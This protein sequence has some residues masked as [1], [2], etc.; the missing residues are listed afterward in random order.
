LIF[1]RSGKRLTGGFAMATQE[2]R[3]RWV[4]EALQTPVIAILYP[5][6]GEK[7]RDARPEDG[8]DTLL[9]SVI[10]RGDGGLLLEAPRSLEVGSPFDLRMKSP[11]SKIWLTY[12]GKVIWGERKPTRLGCFLLGVELRKEATLDPV[13][14]HG[15]STQR[16][17][18]WPSEVEFLLQTPLLLAAPDAAKCC[19]LNCMSQQIVAAGERL[20]SQGDEHDSMYV[21]QEGSCVASVEKDGVTYPINRLKAGDILG[22]MA[23]LTGGRRTA[24][25]DAEEDMKVWRLTAAHFDTLCEEY[26]GLRDFL[27]ELATQRFTTETVTAER[28]VGKYIIQERLGRGGWSIVYKGM[29]GSLNMPVAI[30]MLKHTMAMHPQFSEKFKNEARTIANLNHESIVKV[31]DIEERY[32][33]IFI[34]MEYLD[35]VP[36]DYLLKRTPRLPL[37]RVMDILMQVCAGLAYAHEK[38]IVHQD[39]KPANIFV[40]AIERAKIVDFGLSLPLGTAAFTVS[41]SANYM[42]PEQITGGPVD[43]RSDIYSLGIMAYEMVAGRRPYPED[44]ISKVL[45]MHVREDVPEPHAVV[46]DLPDELCHFIRRATARDP[47]ARYKSAWDALRSLQPLAERMGVGGT[48]HLRE[49]RKNMI[50]SLFY[51]EEHQLTLNRLVEELSRELEKIGA[52]LRAADFKD[53]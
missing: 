44:D 23:L 48:P 52:T 7:Q 27:T 16:K 22:E 32:R 18:I 25:V 10:N 8:D 36:L 37:S 50:L 3:R 12:N 29:H 21:I 33:T 30:K 17:R 51:K 24:H 14:P 41:D 26:P 4:R 43:A 13:S 19:L 42:A 20:I 34:V 45:D 49:Q 53:V 1:C 38:G 39:I 31:Y 5:Q 2:E 35:G 46:P 28:I 47:A 40:Q 9:V 6:H 11:D 15:I